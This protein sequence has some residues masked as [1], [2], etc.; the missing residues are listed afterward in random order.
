MNCLK[1]GLV[2]SSNNVSKCILSFSI[3][4]LGSSK[5]W[6]DWISIGPHSQWRGDFSKTD[7]FVDPP[8]FD[9][10]FGW[11][12]YAWY[13]W[14]GL[15]IRRCWNVMN[16]FAKEQ[17]IG[18]FRESETFTR[19]LHVTLVFWVSPFSSLF[20][21]CHEIDVEPFLGMVWSLLLRE[22]VSHTYYT[23]SCF[24]TRS[25]VWYKIGIC[26]WLERLWWF[27]CDGYIE[28]GWYKVIKLLDMVL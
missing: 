20:L 14:H 19:K 25:I 9:H 15:I 27:C 23:P 3:K 5:T 7:H 2:Q 24:F 4:L 16:A 11:N 10:W 1:L 26:T 12:L 18:G 8:S 17:W 6:I 21:N 22:F 13:A 28:R